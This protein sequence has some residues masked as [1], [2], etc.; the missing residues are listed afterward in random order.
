M[1]ENPVRSNVVFSPRFLRPGLIFLTCVSA[2]LSGC[3]ARKRPSVA[4]NTAILARP[5]TPP[6]AAAAAS[7]TED[8]VPELRLE[9]PAFPLRLISTRSA[10]ARPH[11]SSPASSGAGTDAEKLES[12][13][14][15]PSLSPQETV[16]AQQQTNESLNIAEKNLAATQRKNLNATQSDLVSKILGFMKDAREAA[17]IMDWTRARSLAKK[18]EVLSEELVGSP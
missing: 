7:L 15:A 10:P 14:I 6:R 13:L 5:T 11:V 1:T 8:P 12:P 2:L 16:I 18:A 9:A 3:G 4:W 17:Q